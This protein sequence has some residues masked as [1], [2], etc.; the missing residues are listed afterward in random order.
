VHR[1]AP[2]NRG[3]FLLVVAATLQ[4]FL[5]LY[6]CLTLEC[7]RKEANRSRTEGSSGE[8]ELERVSLSFL[9]VDSPNRVSA[10]RA[11]DD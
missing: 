7:S 9:V 8:E 4:R 10:I 3:A 2:R 5:E 11:V 1:N 6:V